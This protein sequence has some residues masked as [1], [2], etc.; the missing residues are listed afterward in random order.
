MSS[1]NSSSSSSSNRLLETWQN[2]K[3][4]LFQQTSDA[5]RTTTTKSSHHHHDAANNNNN[6]NNTD[7]SFPE[8]SSIREFETRLTALLP[9]PVVAGT[10]AVVVV[11]NNNEEQLRGDQEP[12]PFTRLDH[13]RQFESW[14]CGVACLL[15]ILRWLR[16]NN[17]STTIS[18]IVYPDDST[19]LRHET[20]ERDA[21]LKRIGA[22]SIW[23]AEL[24]LELHKFIILPNKNAAAGDYLFCSKTLQVEMEHRDVG[25]Y[26][27]EFG[28]DQAR[29]TGVFETLREQLRAPMMCLQELPLHHV[30]RAVSHPDCVA[31][32][33]V[34]NSVLTNTNTNTNT[35]KKRQHHSYPYY[36]SSSSS[37]SSSSSQQKTDETDETNEDDSS[38]YQ[39]HYIILCGMSRSKEHLELATAENDDDGIDA[40]D[41]EYCLVLC[42]PNPCTPWMYVTAAKFER[43]WRSQGTDDDIIFIVRRRDVD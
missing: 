20:E 12:P 34:D 37:S 6:N 17:D 19:L 42:N 10:A 39:G 11:A 43:S 1:S 30:L 31:M 13:C 24:V 40:A 22:T 7:S 15:I 32:V 3:A 4:R 21:I 14:D 36:Y 27:S 29:V 5:T 33:L 28:T 16:S 41:I 25:Y 26:Q 23:T 9:S 35:T 2:A 18:S 8:S 38:S